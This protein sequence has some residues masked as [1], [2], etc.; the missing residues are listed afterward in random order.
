M[1][2]FAKTVIINRAVPG[3]G[4][5]TI[6]RCL[7]EALRENGINIGLHSTDDFFMHGNNYRFDIHKLNSYH[8][9]NQLNFEKDLAEARDVVVCDNTNLMP[10]QTEPYTN[11]AR[12]YGYR[13]IMI[14]FLPRE[15][16]KHIKSQIVTP[17]KPDAHGVSESLLAE[18]IRD[19]NNYNPL[20]AQ[21]AEVNPAL[22]HDYRW[23]NCLLK[24]LDT[25]KKAEHFDTDAVITI[26]PDEYHTAKSQIGKEILHFMAV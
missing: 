14:N 6:A 5:T 19:F 20:V 7:N 8:Q 18:F 3:S 16:W 21:E 11:T 23:D 26:R 24:P 9:L 12:K 22:H 17:E 1:N 25:G 4:K 15:L 13:I 2:T 10:W